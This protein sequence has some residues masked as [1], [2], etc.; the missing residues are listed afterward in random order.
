MPLMT[1]EHMPQMPSRQSESKA[2]G[3]WPRAM[4]P[5]LT[6]SSISSNDISGITSRASYASKPPG[7]EPDFCRQTFKVRFMKQSF[8]TPGAHVYFVVR[9]RFLMQHGRFARALVFP[10]GN[11]AE[12]LI[13]PLRF[14]LGGLELLTEMAAA[15]FATM[16]RVEAEQ[17]GKFHEVGDPA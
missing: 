7:A 13:V 9:Q 8:V 14:A 10:G 16:Q 3:S 2:I 6:T 17:F 4:S 1:S 15:R 11:V 5:S 12:I